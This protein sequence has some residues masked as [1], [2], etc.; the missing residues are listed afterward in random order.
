MKFTHN[1]YIP[2]IDLFYSSNIIKSLLAFF[3][4]SHALNDLYIVAE[5]NIKRNSRIWLTTRYDDERRDRRRTR[6][7]KI[8]FWGSM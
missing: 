2:Y 3:G 7:F 1:G 8:N 4:L 6:L 5:N